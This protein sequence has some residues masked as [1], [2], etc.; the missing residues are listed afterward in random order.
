MRAIIT[1]SLFLVFISQ[2]VASGVYRWVDSEGNTHFGDR[3]PT[4]EAEQIKAPSRVGGEPLPL[5]QATDATI[6]ESAKVQVELWKQQHNYKRALED[7]DRAR[8][9]RKELEERGRAFQ[10][11]FR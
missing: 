2:A 8:E 4:L 1:L 9:R 6:S 5:E 7:L 3:P 10:E 11:E